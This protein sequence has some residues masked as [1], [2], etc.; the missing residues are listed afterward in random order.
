MNSL[1]IIKN[2]RTTNG[3]LFISENK[4]KTNSRELNCDKIVEGS[5]MT[6]KEALTEDMKSFRDENTSFKSRNIEGSY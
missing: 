1:R 6:R 4:N 3:V 5:I 2:L